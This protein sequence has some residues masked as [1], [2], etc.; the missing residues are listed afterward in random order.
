MK[1][2][3]EEQLSQRYNFTPG[4]TERKKLNSQNSLDEKKNDKK[5]VPKNKI[6]EADS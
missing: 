5:S 4:V 2:M 1:N 3:N 6:N